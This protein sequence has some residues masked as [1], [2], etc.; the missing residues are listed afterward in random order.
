M[1]IKSIW[2]RRIHKWVGLVI[3]LQ[4]V[5]WA[6]SGAAMALC[7]M[8]VVAGGARPELAE[9]PLQGEAS[10]WPKIAG[11]LATAKIEALRLRTVLDR[12]VVEVRTSESTQIFDASTGVR[13][14]IDAAAARAIAQASHPQ[15]A[16]PVAATLLTEASLAVRNHEPPIW[17]IEFAD[18]QASSYY[19]SATTGALLERRNDT[20][21][22][23]DFFWM[24]HNMDYANRTSFNH[25]LIIAAGIGMVW[26][27]LTGFWLLFRTMWRH[28][29]A[30]AR[31]RRITGRG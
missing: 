15:F 23:W 19:V 6:I 16:T 22:W 9:A 12:P 4:F 10:G 2:L 26:L 11:Q 30:W 21:R 1:K 25:P 13:L 14:A 27:A 8:E 17:Q 5:L 3:G 29:L 20:W 18:G 28:D 7:D 24:L 31:K